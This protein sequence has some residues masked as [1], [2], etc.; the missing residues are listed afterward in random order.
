R[1]R[2]ERADWVRSEDASR[3]LDLVVACAGIS[4]ETGKPG[5]FPG[6][7]EQIH[8]VNVVGLLNTVEPV[9]S[10][11][12][13]RGRGQIGL[14]ASVSGFCGFP[15]RP[16]YSSSKAAVIALGQAWRETLRH[17]GI[18]VTTICPGYMQTAMTAA[19]R[20]RMP[21]LID[22]AVAAPLVVRALAANKSRLVFPWPLPVVAWLFR[23][24]PYPL[25]APFLPGNKRRGVDGTVE[26]R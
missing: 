24:L 21:F 26:H 25:I 15:R 14:V 17:D 5:E 2:E 13:A 8:R 6:H 12:R 7:A 20:F 22:P 11:M 1:E 4:G 16:A 3:P 18:G 23:A 19:N 10:A 9:L